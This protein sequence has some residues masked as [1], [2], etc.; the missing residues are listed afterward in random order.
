MESNNT[1]DEYKEI[2]LERIQYII[3][4]EKGETTEGNTCLDED[5]V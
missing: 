1:D 3:H 5:T 2:S 4:E